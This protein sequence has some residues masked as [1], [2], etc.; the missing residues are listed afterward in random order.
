MRTAIKRLAIWAYCNGLLP[1]GIVA[2]LFAL[3]RLK[4]A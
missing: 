4:G 2:K 3:L 1:A